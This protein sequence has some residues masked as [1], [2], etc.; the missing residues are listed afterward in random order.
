MTHRAPQE[1]EPGVPSAL[2]EQDPAANR[3]GWRLA[4]I[5]AA[6]AWV[7]SRI[8]Y[9]L[10]NLMSWRA[11]HMAPPET[12]EVL[13]VWGAWDSGH[14][15]RIA[16][17][18]YGQVE[19]DNAFFPLYPLL[20]RFV[21]AVLPGDGLIAAL[22]VSNLACFGV[23]V[24][25]HRLTA[26]EL[27]ES[28]ARRTVFYLVA[29]PTAF[30]LAAPYNTS[31]FLLLTVG[32]LYA[33]RRGRWWVAGVLAG[34]AS[35][36]RSSGVL[37]ALPFAF[38]YLR[39]RGFRWRSIR[40]DAL[41]IFLVPSGLIAFMLYCWRAL[42]DPLAF[43]HAQQWWYRVVD[44]PF[45][46]LYRT[47]AEARQAQQEQGW[48]A[49]LTVVNLTDFAAGLGFLVL[50][51]LCL[52]GPWRLRR[53]QLYLV[54]YGFVVVLFPLANPATDARPLISM[55]RFVLECVPAFMLLGRMGRS[56][57]VDRL[58]PMPAIALQVTFLLVFLHY[59]WI[60]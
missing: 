23:L 52:V 18:G 43:S 42:G 39:V 11:G 17:G 36:T 6:L 4:V 57:L 28:T 27:G 3:R 12:S 50:M 8:A 54:I 20:I 44:W 51:T 53:D 29:F 47:L 13:Q 5:S 56:P 38:E 35:A 33:L 19:F 2:P 58:Y 22:V 59:D 31:L 49:E 45:L 21:D 14:Y 1:P 46:S 40:W 34:L 9:G 41:S 30:F 16:A 32:A 10:V 15:L 55:A 25:L 24:L 26:L 60:A 37:L 7:A 48:L